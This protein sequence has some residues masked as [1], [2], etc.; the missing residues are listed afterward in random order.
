MSSSKKTMTHFCSTC[1]KLVPNTFRKPHR[2]NHNPTLCNSWFLHKASISTEAI[3][4][5]VKK[6]PTF[7]NL[8]KLS[9]LIEE[10]S[11]TWAV[12]VE[13]NLQDITNRC[14][15]IYSK[16]RN[17]IL[18]EVKIDKLVGVEMIIGEYVYHRLSTNHLNF[19]LYM[20][21]YA[22]MYNILDFLKV[23]LS[24]VR[25]RKDEREKPNRIYD[26]VV[27]DAINYIYDSVVS[28]PDS[29][30]YNCMFVYESDKFNQLDNQMFYYGDLGYG[31]GATNINGFPL[32][33]STLN[34]LVDRF[35][36]Q[37]VVYLVHKGDNEEE[38]LIDTR[39]LRTDI[40]EELVLYLVNRMLGAFFSIDLS[41]SSRTG[42]ILAYL[43]Q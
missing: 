9:D 5:I 21:S 35:K 32:R 42:N 14:L 6:T 15:T 25:S 41:S 23:P 17:I 12:N 43:Y 3:K 20:T 18:Q 36:E 27:Y 28:L 16:I 4:N 40:I 24:E 1:K 26:F 34:I 13:P 37:M 31:T 10:E 11:M 38:L 22:K 7:P 33:A 29:V 39:Q 2:Q 19:Q 8:I 30:L